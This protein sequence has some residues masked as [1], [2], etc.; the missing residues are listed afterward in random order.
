MPDFGSYL[1]YQ[2]LPDYET[3]NRLLKSMKE[4]E[5]FLKLDKTT[6]K[7]LYSILVECLENNI[8]HSSVSPAF[9]PAYNSYITA[10]NLGTRIEIKTGNLN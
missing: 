10:R 6:G 5:L 2:G 4:S 8:R 1:E 9:N 7:R 3:I